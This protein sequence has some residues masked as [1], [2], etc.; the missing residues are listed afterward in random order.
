ALGSDII[1]REVQLTS[2]GEDKKPVIV[3]MGDVAAS[4]GYYISMEADQV[5]ANP[6]TVT[7]S[8]GVV[9]GEF[10]FKE[11]F[12]K[13]GV[14]T[15]VLKRGEQADLLDPA[16]DLTED[17]RSRIYELMMETYQS[18]VNKA[19]QGRGMS[20][21]AVDSLGR[22]RIYSGRRA[23]QAGLID[24]LGGIAQAISLARI[25]AGIPP[26]RSVEFEY[27]PKYAVNLFDLLGETPTLQSK[28]N[29]P[30]DIQEALQQVEQ[31]TFLTEEQVLYL[32]PYSIRMD[33]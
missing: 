11:L 18:F 3:S 25:A 30:E 22:G 15:Q 27:Y 32:L 29:L 21:E 26:E 2:S 24:E 20:P 10:V 9:F 8:I 33:E 7:G 17:E 28:F 12:D 1:W 31:M 16:S 6:E 19:A 13:I 5:L 14:H 4:G 23:Q